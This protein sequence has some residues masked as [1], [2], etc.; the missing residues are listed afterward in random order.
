V[1]NF[2]LA[3]LLAAA[4][5]VTLAAPLAAQ[6]AR[7]PAAAKVD[8][9]A[10]TA[11]KLDAVLAGAHRSDAN[12]ARDAY[13]HPKETLLFF[14]LTPDKTVIEITP[15]AGWY[16]EVVAPVVNGRGLYIAAHN[17]PNGSPGA[18]KQRAAFKDKLAANPE[19]FGKAVVTSFG[20][21][22]ENN[23]AAPGSADMVLTFRNVHNWMGAGFAPDAFKA[24]YTALKPGGV[25]GV[26]EHRMPEDR[27]DT[28]ENRRS[29]YVKQSDVIRMAE[30]AG[31]KLDASSEINANPKDTADH[32][33]GVWTLPPNFAMG[34]ADK[35]KF[36]AIGESDR[37][38]LRFV[39]P[40]G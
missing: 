25:L 22:I 10:E 24:F 26:V 8:P 5:A 6:A 27:P 16:T 2:R 34:D 20:K 30:A 14:G 3:A 39:K 40:R 33:K 21:G 1:I 23:I 11:A 13:R 28:D 4:A 7:K 19:L 37:M 35:A 36:Q 15:G 12:R 17:N 31:F 38:T 9:A 32:P 29:G 18:Q